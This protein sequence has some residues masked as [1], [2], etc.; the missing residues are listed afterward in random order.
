MQTKAILRDK[1]DGKKGDKL[2]QDRCNGERIVT[3]NFFKLINSM[4]PKV[5]EAH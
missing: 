2:K 4:N 3:I 1:K 5:R